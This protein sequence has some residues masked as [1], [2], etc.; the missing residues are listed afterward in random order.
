MKKNK[1]R[2]TGIILLWG[3]LFISLF[4][5]SGISKSLS[6][7]DDPEKRT[8]ELFQ[9]Y[10]IFGKENYISGDISV[11]GF[12]NNFPTYKFRL[13]AKKQS[14]EAGIDHPPFVNNYLRLVSDKG[15]SIVIKG[16]KADSTYF[17]WLDFASLKKRDNLLSLSSSIK[18]FLNRELV[19]TI[20]VRKKKMFSSPIRIVINNVF[21]SLEGIKIELIPF[22][23]QNFFWGVHDVYVTT[24]PGIPPG[25][26]YRDYMKSN[27]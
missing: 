11:R 19:K 6:K 23:G 25:Y 9:S 14:L 16:L 7:K 15:A 17:L 5:S 22:E 1:L 12:V 13:W 24:K 27:L 10:V 2:L 8:R 26:I 18:I 21:K 4:L 3:L 20:Y